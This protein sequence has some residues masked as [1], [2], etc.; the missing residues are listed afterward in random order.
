VAGSVDRP[1]PSLPIG[2]RALLRIT[3]RGIRRVY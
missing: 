3:V 1:P 2:V